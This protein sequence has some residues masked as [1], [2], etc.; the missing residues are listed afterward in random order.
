MTYNQEIQLF[1]DIVTN[2]KQLRSFG[3]GEEWELNG[4]IKAGFQNYTLYAVP[5]EAN[6]TE[7]TIQT[8]FMLICCGVAFKDK[9]NEDEIVSDCR[10]ILIDIHKI[11]KEHDD[12]D[13]S[14]TNPMIPFKEEYG[15]WM[16]GWRQE[17][18][19]E[20]SLNNNPCDMPHNPE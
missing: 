7:N 12:F 2:H 10:S 17:I 18:I 8:T 5:I 20:S 13:I 14:S 4:T 11:I 9:S 6:T 3:T 16:A 19:L 1:R 15:D